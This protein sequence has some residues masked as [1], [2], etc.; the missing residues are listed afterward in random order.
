LGRLDYFILNSGDVELNGLEIK[1]SAFDAFNLPISVLKGSIGHFK[2]K[3]PWK[4]LGSSSVV[5]EISDVY[6][7]VRPK[8]D[9][10]WNVKEELEKSNRLKQQKLDAFEFLKNEKKKD[11]EKKT[12]EEK[13]N[14]P[15]FMEKLT[16]TIINNLQVKIEN[17]HVRYE[18]V[19]N[20][21]NP[22][23]FGFSLE[24]VTIGSC[25]R[26]FEKTFIT[27]GF[28]FFL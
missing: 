24:N 12:G 3:I 22:I 14:D 8:K 5:V 6:L 4:A 27:E 20:S 23:V 10:Q 13:Q 25:N 26:Y 1:G 11:L 9:C 15:G 16:E 17:V 2:L 18:D 7:L 19:T 21:K 28:L